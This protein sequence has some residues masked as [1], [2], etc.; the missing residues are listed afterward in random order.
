MIIM[1][2][3]EMVSFKLGEK[4]G[5]FVSIPYSFRKFHVTQNDTSDTY[6][7]AITKGRINS[8]KIQLPKAEYA[9][10]GRSHEL[11]PE[12]IESSFNVPFKDYLKLLNEKD[13]TINYSGNSNLWAVLEIK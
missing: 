12:F 9:F 2:K 7:I 5:L 4:K 11:E 13:I 3:N 6:L 1:N 10:L 8:W